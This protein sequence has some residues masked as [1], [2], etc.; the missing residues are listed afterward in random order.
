M[1]HHNGFD[2]RTA[3][4][5]ED[6]ASQAQARGEIGDA[7]LFT[8]QAARLYRDENA[9][10]AAR[11]YHKAFSLYLKARQVDDALRQANDSFHMLDYSGW[12]EK[13][14]EQVLDLKEMI[15]ELRCAGFQ[16]EAAQ[17]AGILNHKLSQFGLM[18]IP[19][20]AAPLPS[21]CPT[22]GAA[23]PNPTPDG[24]VRCSFCGHLARG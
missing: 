10:I 1:F 24:E 3:D 16:H 13:S 21:V 4:Q 2:K 7:A 14:M 5:L 17:F 22:C 20:G 11:L 19:D 23:L 18:L 6:K 12:L 15:G 9:L 8:V